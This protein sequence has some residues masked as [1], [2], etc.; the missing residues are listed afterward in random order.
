[1][2]KVLEIPKGRKPDFEIVQE[3]LDSQAVL[4]RLSG[5]VNPLHVDPIAASFA[6]F[7]RPILHGLCTF[8]FVGRAV[9]RGICGNRVDLIKEFGVRFAAP[10]YPN[11]A[12]ATQGWNMGDGMHFLRAACKGREV[13]SNAYARVRE[14]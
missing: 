5:D 7:P 9:L 4:Y 8:G 10:V 2:A 11:E 1:M 3:T 13:L 12:I 14:A 6:G